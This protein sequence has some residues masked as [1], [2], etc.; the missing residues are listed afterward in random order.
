MSNPVAFFRRVPLHG[1]FVI[2]LYYGIIC[3]S[4]AIILMWA[5]Q[6]G[7]QSI[8][9][10]LNYTVAFG[11]YAPMAM[12]FSWPTMLIFLMAII[13][14]APLFAIVSIFFTSAVYHVCL[15]I[16]GGANNGYEAT[17]RAI[18]Y[19]SSAQVLGVIPIVGSVVAGIWAL[20]L[21]IIGLKEMHKTTYARAI[22]AVLLPVIIC[23]GFIIL[24]VATIF[25]A[26]L[27]SWMGGTEA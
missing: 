7:F 10:I 3:H 22:L 4:V 26:A 9:I 14:I 20:V 17:F 25:G 18:N 15:K 12:N 13:V 27:G 5:Y 19:G 6:A 16:F 11:G 24:V 2:P 23:C 8:P 21:N 1:N